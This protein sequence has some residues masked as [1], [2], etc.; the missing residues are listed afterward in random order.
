M[1]GREKIDGAVQKPLPEIALDLRHQLKSI[2]QQ[3][4]QGS[5]R[6]AWRIKR[7]AGDAAAFGKS[8]RSCAQ[9]RG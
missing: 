6:A 1:S 4:E 2:R 9:D 3:R 5:F 8:A 7:V